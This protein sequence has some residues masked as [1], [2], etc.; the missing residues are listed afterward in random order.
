MSFIEPALLWGAA[1]VG[2]P[3]AI[4]FWHQKRGKLMPWAATLW[5]TERDQTQN[6]GVHFQNILLF[7][8]RCLLL[9]VLALLLSRPILNGLTRPPTAHRIHLVQ[10]NQLLTDNFRFELDEA[11]KR[12]ETVYWADTP[13][14]PFTTDSLPGF[15]KPLTFGPI[16]LQRALNQLPGGNTELHLYLVNDPSL[17]E[18][19]AF[20]VPK[21]FRL[22]TIV[23][24]ANQPR[25]YLLVNERKKLFI[26][27]TGRLISSPTPD[28]TLRFRAKPA[29]SGVLRVL[30]N[31]RNNREQ[32]TVRAA[33]QALADGYALALQYDAKPQPGILYD[34]VLTDQVPVSPDRHTL[35]IVSGLDPFPASSNVVYTNETLTPQTSE[36]VANGQLPE[37][38]GEQLLRYYDLRTTQPPLSAQALKALF[39]PSSEPEQPQQ[40]GVQNA[41]TLLFVVLLMAERWLALTKSA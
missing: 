21:S 15:Q 6:R 4:H 33:L 24:S 41:L 25:P 3:I 17:A 23:D 26:S 7:V 30:L 36:R 2:I 18:V 39:R 34:W 40:A 38:L 5:L 12:N 16:M 29:H 22:H 19:P 31:Y 20:T 28:P 1:A 37:W 35:Y 32:Q 27:H 14:A 10:P 8:L 9:I 11:R 13:L